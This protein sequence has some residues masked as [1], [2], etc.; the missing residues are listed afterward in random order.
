MPKIPEDAEDLWTELEKAGST[1]SAEPNF[2]WFSTKSVLFS[3]K[4]T[5]IYQNLP[6]FTKF[7]KFTP[8][9]YQVVS[10]FYQICYWIVVI[11]A[12]FPPN[13]DSQK[14][15]VDK[16]MLFPALHSKYHW[17]LLI[18]AYSSVFQCISAYSSISQA[19]PA[20]FFK[21]LFQPISAYS[22]LFHLIPFYSTLLKP[23]PAYFKRF[24][25]IPAYSS[26]FQ[27]VPT[28][29]SPFQPIIDRPGVAGAVL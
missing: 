8:N 27:S 16:K 2:F 19:I 13:L 14:A 10:N 1:G 22:I 3:A 6:T 21:S 28:Y 15:R 9:L 26:L 23:S 25:P 11:Y 4:F 20:S 29:S 17:R 5:K 12:L 18:P 24:Q 7:T